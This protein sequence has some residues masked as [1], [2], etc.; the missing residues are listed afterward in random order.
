MTVYQVEPDSLDEVRL[1]PRL[2]TFLDANGIDPTTVPR[3]AVVEV[4]GHE[5]RVET[6]VFAADGRFVIEAGA[7]ARQ[8]VTVPLTVPMA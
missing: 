5:I 3:G 8:V 2:R 4:V 6:F 1:L 7:P